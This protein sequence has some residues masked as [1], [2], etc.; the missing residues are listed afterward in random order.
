MAL[1]PTTKKAI[2]ITV[3]SVV[4]LMVSY[5]VFGKT[6]DWRIIVVAAALSFGLTYLVVSKITKT[7]Y[8][9]GP[10]PVPTGGGCDD[11]DPTALVDSI[12]EDCTCT[13]CFRDRS[14]YDKLLGLADCQLRKAHNYW[15][16]KY[17]G[18]TG[19]S[20]AL[21]IADQGNSFDSKFE[22]QQSALKI[23][24]STLNLQ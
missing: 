24:F 19:K 13:F 20:L 6:K 1:T 16:T 17:Y 7:A 22:Q 18:D 8:I 2:D 12:Y 23:K 15:N 21:I 10:A 3:P 9:D 5:F 14:L 11:Y 4:A